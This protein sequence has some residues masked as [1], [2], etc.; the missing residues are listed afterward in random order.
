MHYSPR[1]YLETCVVF[2]CSYDTHASR[3]GFLSRSA[4]PDDIF[5]CVSNAAS[6][7][8]FR[9][10]FSQRLSPHTILP[11]SLSF[12]SSRLLLFLPDARTLLIML[13]VYRLY[14]FASI[15]LLPPPPP[16][17]SKQSHF[18]FACQKC[19]RP[20]SCHNLSI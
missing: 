14:A 16:L 4:K 6:A 17:P 13:L 7:R 10:L 19:L 5:A 12:S 15:L 18:Y 3:A 11:L 9:C 20:H 2:T 8:V 1:L